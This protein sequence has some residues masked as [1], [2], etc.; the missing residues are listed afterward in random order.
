[1]VPHQRHAL[2]NAAAAALCLFGVLLPAVG[3]EWALAA[4]GILGLTALGRVFYRTSVVNGVPT[5]ERDQLINLRA[6]QI[7]VA[8][9]WI[10]AAQAA[11]AAFVR[12]GG[13][14]S[15]PVAAFPA[16]VLAGWS[17][18]LLAHSVASLALY[19]RVGS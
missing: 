14:A 9:F 11:T 16:A 19:R 13:A 4:F 15:V 18:F 10:A 12:R 7:A 6:I 5:D 3:L 8:V 2:F 17:L 1:M